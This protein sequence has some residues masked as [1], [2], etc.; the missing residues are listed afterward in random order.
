MGDATTS[1]TMRYNYRRAAT[2]GDTGLIYIPEGANQ[3]SKMVVLDPETFT[4]TTVDMPLDLL[5]VNIGLYGCM[6]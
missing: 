4:M 1:A 6:E 5:P 3:G 2:D